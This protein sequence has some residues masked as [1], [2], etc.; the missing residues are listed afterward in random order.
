MIKANK[1]SLF[2]FQSLDRRPDNTPNLLLPPLCASFVRLNLKDF[3]QRWKHNTSLPP[4]DHKWYSKLPNA[5][6]EGEGWLKVGVGR[7]RGTI[8]LLCPRSDQEMRRIATHETMFRTKYTLPEHFTRSHKLLQSRSVAREAHQL[9]STEIYSKMLVS[10]SAF[11]VCRVLSQ[12]WE[13]QRSR[14]GVS[15][16]LWDV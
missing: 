8:H 13:H 9:S 3:V 11:P 2:L 12:V 4:G 5:R 7:S 16:I 14:H 1:Y 15:A 10:Y 6:Q